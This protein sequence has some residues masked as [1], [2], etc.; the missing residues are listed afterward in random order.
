MATKKKRKLK[1][2][3]LL[4]ILL[5]ICLLIGGGVFLSYS[6]AQKPVQSQS[7]E[8][9]FTI[10]S[11]ESFS[12]VAKHLKER[13]I[14]KSDFWAKVYAKQHDLGNLK[15][16]QY[17]LDKSWDLNKILTYLND[18]RA[19]AVDVDSVTIIP[20]DWV[21]HI[22]YKISEKTNL[23]QDELINEWN[24]VGYIQSLMADYPFITDEVFNENI[25]NK[26]EGYF[27][28][29]TY[30]FFRETS[31]DDGT[32]KIL[33]E[34][35]IIYNKYADQMAKSSLSIHQ[36]YT[37]ASI[38]QYEAG[39]VQNMKMIAGV[40]YNRLAAGMPLQSSVTV[41]YAIDRTQD[42][43]WMSCEVNSNFDS[44]YN[45]YQVQGLPPGPIMNPSEAAIEAVLNPTAS[46]YYYFMADVLGDGTVYYAKTL[47][48]HNAN[49]AKYLK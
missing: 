48:E 16:G 37:L 40:F 35:L 2:G 32:R 7:E 19:A 23:T 33:D 44:P 22:A 46:D 11:G 29:N 28:P 12:Q 5:V 30:E 10:D 27:A 3:R 43:D 47:A 24:N 18:P 4:V 20:G 41:C 1:V 49:V 42:D 39:D 31:V 8:I 26:L 9:A 6:N 17:T 15:M 21:K 45:T 38:V 25:R 13:G 36:I 14:I 34:S